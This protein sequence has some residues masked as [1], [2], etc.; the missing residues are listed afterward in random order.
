M[1]VQTLEE[2]KAENAKVEMEA[3]VQ[4]ASTEEE[5]TKKA[6]EETEV[7]T[8]QVAESDQNETNEDTVESW[9]QTDDDTSGN[10]ETLTDSDAATIRRKWK[11]K[12]KKAEEEHNTEVEQLKA[13]LNQYQ[14]QSQ[15][16]QEAV[17]V[18]TLEGCDYDEGV[19]QQKMAEYMQGAV[20]NQLQSH[21]ASSEQ[22]AAQERAKKQMEDAVHSHYE[23]ASKLKNITA[24]QFQ[25]S[26]M[27][28]RKVVATVPQFGEQGADSVVDALI[29]SMGDGSEKLMYYLGRNKAAQS[30]FKAALE[31]DQS[32]LRAGIL[33]GEMKATVTQ[34]VKKTSSAPKPSAK[35][36]GD[37][38]SV[39]ASNFKR[40]Y[41]KAKTPQE[42]F[43]IRQEA[44]EA[45]ENVRDW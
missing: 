25:A 13:Q 26:D 14:N 9:M 38:Q 43:N 2:L 18:P 8:S 10:E 3:E 42:R 28:V 36:E 37:G 34:P 11:G 22:R 31:A 30:K 7:E 16:K 5:I 23:R 32:G 44:R 1:Q 19:Y 41:D 40:K 24:E 33:L 6:T 17:S 4:P 45:G 39:A 20:A 12:L 29:S 21:Q 27:E 15:P 35:A